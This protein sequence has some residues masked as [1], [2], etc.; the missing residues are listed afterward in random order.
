M[1]WLLAEWEIGI[2]FGCCGV[3]VGMDGVYGTGSI[4]DG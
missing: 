1:G 3:I 2:Y 4:H